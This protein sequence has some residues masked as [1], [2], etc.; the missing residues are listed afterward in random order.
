ML[1]AVDIGNTHTGLGIFHHGRLAATHRLSTNRNATTAEIWETIFPFL[2]GAGLNSHT[3][4]GIGISSVVPEA[5]MTF[6]ALASKQFGRDPIIVSGDLPLGIKILYDAPATLGADRICNAVAGFRKYGGPLIVIDAGT[7]T[8]Y[9][10]INE[11]GD[12]LGGAIA[13]GLGM[14]AAALHRRTAQLPEIE[15]KPPSSVI[16]HNTRSAMQ[17]GVVV[18]GIE[19]MEGLV[20]RI[21]AEL[22][23][24]AKVIAT[25]GLSPQIAALSPIITACEP[26]LVLEGVRLI[27]EQF[28]ST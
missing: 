10:V 20:R 11:R 21:R 9:D 22:G 28:Q 27:V 24:P 13:L 5:T 18:G 3:L 14:Q 26:F 12:F 25:G 16:A 17:A 1:L 23:S 4:T 7:A 15:L 6:R 8:T 2:T 19:A